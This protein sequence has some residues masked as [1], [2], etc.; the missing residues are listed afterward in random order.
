MQ[1]LA[2]KSDVEKYLPVAKGCKANEINFYLLEEQSLTLT[3]WLGDCFFTELSTKGDEPKFQVLLQGGVWNEG[4]NN[5]AGLIKVLAYLAYGEYLVF[6]N[7]TD[8]PFGIKIK[9]YQDGLP[10][11]PEQL[12]TL[13]LRYR[14]KGIAYF[15]SCKEY[16]CANR[17]YFCYKGDCGDK[18]GCKS[19]CGCNGHEKSNVK[20]RTLY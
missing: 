18:C 1:Q 7:F 20:I 5:C 9:N 11:P 15:E 16:L 19:E 8:T 10:T 2:D 17:E 13:R 14:N 12:E 6:N 4:K 3:K